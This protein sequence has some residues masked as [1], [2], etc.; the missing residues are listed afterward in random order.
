VKKLLGITRQQ[1]TKTIG[2]WIADAGAKTA[3]KESGI[4]STC[5]KKSDKNT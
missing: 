2:K 1:W 3:V 4:S 5:Q